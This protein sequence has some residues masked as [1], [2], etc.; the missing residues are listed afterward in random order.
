MKNREIVEKILSYHP[1]IPNYHGCDSWKAGDPE[2]ECTG[3]VTALVPTVNVIRKARALGANLLI[4]HEPTFTPPRTAQAGLKIFPT[5]SMRRSGSFWRS[6]GS[7]YG[8]TTTICT[9]I[10]RTASSPAF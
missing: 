2:A 9:F 5:G 1:H 7:L 3:I 10:S 4:V 8:G 6:P